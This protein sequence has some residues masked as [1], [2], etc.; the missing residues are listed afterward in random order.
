[1]KGV[2]QTLRVMLITV[3][4]MLMGACQFAP[5]ATAEYREGM[6]IEPVSRQDDWWISRHQ[7]KL[8]EKQAL[9]NV[10]LVFLGDSITHSWEKRGKAAWDRFYRDRNALNLGYS[11]DKTENVLWRLQNGEVEGIDPSLLVLMIGTNNA[12]HRMEPSQETA[13]GIKAILDELALRLPSTKVLLLAIFPRGKDDSNPYRQLTMGTNEI[14]KGFAD[15]QR[16][17]WLNI[18]G[19]FLDENRILQRSVMSDLLH[20]NADQYTVWATAIEPMVQQLMAE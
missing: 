17:H 10:Q 7:Q 6:S 8:K 4:L 12:G 18:N 1:M 16:V 5:H 13:D 20:P 9:G 19:E 14:I 2:T 11:G 15:G 3:F